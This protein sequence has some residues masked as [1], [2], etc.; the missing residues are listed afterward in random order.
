MR[1]AVALSRAAPRTASCLRPAGRNLLSV[2]TPEPFFAALN[3][4]S[5]LF[6]PGARHFSEAVPPDAESSR[7]TVSTTES[8]TPSKSDGPGEAQVVW[9]APALTPDFE[10]AE[11][12]VSFSAC[13]A[14]LGMGLSLLGLAP[15]VAPGPFM[16]GILLAVL[17]VRV[18]YLLHI[19]GLRGQLRRHVT[20][21]T[22]SEDEKGAMTLSLLCDGNL[23]RVLSLAPASSETETKPSVGKVLRQGFFVYID[24]ELEKGE[25]PKMEELLKSDHVVVEESMAIEP[26]GDEPLD[27]A[28]KRKVPLRALELRDGI[29]PS[30][31][32]SM[33][34][35]SKLAQV[36]AAILMCG[37]LA[38]YV[39]GQRQAA[40]TIRASAATEQHS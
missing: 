1:A 16:A 13:A 28:N 2:A 26:L 23:T 24:R 34:Q 38:I 17:Q 31:K 35:L 20:K 9:Q 30:P 18:A 5:R 37:G 22:L 39:S 8:D 3:I 40:E 19:R 21:A 25:W 14:S 6:Q 33:D 11:M 4:R 36:T 15:H 7:E 29:A 10:Q 32:L 27:E 12:T